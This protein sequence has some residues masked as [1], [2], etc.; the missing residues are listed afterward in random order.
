MKFK[1]RKVEGANYEWA[2]FPRP[3]GPIAFCA[4]AVLDYKP[5]EDM[6]P[7]PRAPKI[8]VVGGAKKDDVDDQHYK[9]A[10]SRHGNLRYA[11]LVVW[12]LKD[13]PGLEWETV[14]LTDPDSWLNWEREL[15]E[16]GFTS[17]E[18]NI[19]QMAIANANGLNSA[20]IEEAR[21]S[22]L[23][24]EASAPS[25]SSFPRDEQPTTPSGEPASGSASVP[26]EQQPPGTSAT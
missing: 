20:K 23:L 18:I 22:F 11:Y 17:N 15:R 8:M 24:S 26:Q 14:R 1:G 5:F 7:L 25:E 12:S 13:S 16:A 19:L 21:A 2:V 10:I 3:D 6:V 9:A 4:R